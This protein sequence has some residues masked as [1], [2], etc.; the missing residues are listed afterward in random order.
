MDS[1]PSVNFIKDLQKNK[2]LNK[3]KFNIKFN[4]VSSASV[5]SFILKLHFTINSFEIES[6]ALKPI[7]Y[8]RRP[9]FRKLDLKLK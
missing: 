1:S 3:C 4:A 2:F 7:P 5:S 9:P 6:S 8:L